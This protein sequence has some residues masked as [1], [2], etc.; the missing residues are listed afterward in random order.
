M[1]TVFLLNDILIIVGLSAL[2]LYICHRV[3]IP[4]VLGFLLTGVITGPHGLGL[5]RDIATV[6]ILAD[7]GVVLLLFA[8]GLEFSFRNLLQMRRTVLLGGSLQVA[9][10]SI[11]AFAVARYSGQS[12]EESV[13]IGFLVSLSSTAIVLKILQ[14]RAELE[15]PQGNTALGILIFQDIIV[16]PMMLFIPLL[17]GGST[18]GTDA[19][20]F[21]FVKV[22]LIILLVITSAKW[23]VPRL[24]YHIASTKSRELFLLSVIALCFAVAWVTSMAGLS[25]A[26]GAFLAG[27]IISESEYSHQ[28]LGSILPFRDVFMSFFFVSVGMLLDMIFF[29]K[30]PVSLTGMA[31]GVLI[32]KAFIVTSLSVFMGLP[33]RL[34]VL[35]GISLSQVGEF[36]FIL[37]G[38][39]LQYGLLAG[40]L[41]QVFLVVSVLTMMATPFAVSAAPG[42]AGA[43][44]KLPLPEN[45]RRVSSSACD[46]GGDVRI[47]DHLII[48]GFGLNGRNLAR[49][50]AFSGIPYVIVEMNPVTV[51][52]ERQRGE[53]IYYGDATEEAILRQMNITEARAIVVVINDPAATRR[54]T[55]LVRRLNPRAYLI[56]RT[57]FLQEMVPLSELG[58]DEVIPEEFETSVEIFSRVLT[59]YLMPKE[60]IERFVAEIRAEGYEMLRSLSRQATGYR[61]LESCLPDVEIRS[62]RLATTSPFVGKTL[63]ETEM[64]KK[65]GVTLLAIRRKEQIISNPDAETVFFPEDILFVVGKP[66]KIKEVIHLLSPHKSDFCE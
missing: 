58:A 53:P 8:I 40:D 37:S 54:I 56:V 62:F 66:E 3:K 64:R 26:L 48:V 14:E 41:H 12:V 30:Q 55:E 27:L 43:I 28:A 4:I 21:F 50:A 57:R 29:L 46:G 52:E 6:Q 36:S 33:L 34:A 45:V 42:I 9:V 15:T 10:T 20:F 49:A 60:E 44:L 39:A 16:V 65:T 17:A 19:L 24:L 61:D 51:R 63:A 2:V 18:M 1:H 13:L 38:T 11:V 47:K 31:L 22:I 59:K 25:L 5:V 23:V 7:V 35:V 32:I